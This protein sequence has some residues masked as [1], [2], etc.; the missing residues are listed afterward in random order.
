VGELVRL[1]EDGTELI[2]SLPNSRGFEERNEFHVTDFGYEEMRAVADRFPDAVVV[3]QY[4]AEGSLILMPDA[5]RD[6][7]AHGRL[8]DAG[9]P[10]ASSE[11]WANHWLILVGVDA[12]QREQA[13]AGLGF[14]TSPH[15]N[16]YMR[17]LERAN[18]ELLRANLRMGRAWLGVHDAAAG[19]AEA[20]RVR[21]E[22]RVAE[23]EQ[24]V[25]HHKTALEAPRYRA[26]DAIRELAFSIPGVS[27]LLRLRSRMLRR[28][29]RT[30]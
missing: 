23:L 13:R 17:Q 30:R 6:S 16:Q 27:T 1:A 21:L 25:L 7:E 3:S 22:A 5:A 4:L 9:S 18:A 8:V 2:I 10:E 14:V 20:R 15:H 24:L 28:R 12:A 11:V 29:R 19:A 26:V